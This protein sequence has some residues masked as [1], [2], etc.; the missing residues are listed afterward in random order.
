MELKLE[1]YVES[2]ALD[3]WWLLVR[4]S[5]LLLRRA[6]SLEGLSGGLPSYRVTFFGVEFNFGGGT[7]SYVV[8][9]FLLDEVTVES[10]TVL[11]LTTDDS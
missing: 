10:Y 3:R 4:P 2:R 8:L 1:L 7:E 9:D 11:R 5:G 6:T